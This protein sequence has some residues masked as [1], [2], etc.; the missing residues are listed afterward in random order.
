[1]LILFGLIGL[2]ISLAARPK[3]WK[4]VKHACGNCGTKLA[5]WE[6]TG[7]TQLTPPMIEWRNRKAMEEFYN[8][9]ALENIPQPRIQEMK[10]EKLP[11][12]Q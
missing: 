2:G 10:D 12:Y 4:D 6:R 7:R 1:M 11:A 5:R 9:A 3:R 8:R